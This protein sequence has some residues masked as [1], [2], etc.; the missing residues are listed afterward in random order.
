MSHACEPCR[1]ARGSVL[2]CVLTLVMTSV[3]RGGPTTYRYDGLITRADA[4]TGVDVGTKFV[5]SFLYDLGKGPT[6]VV[7]VAGGRTYEFGAITPPPVTD[8]SCGLS[9]TVGGQS[10]LERWGNV[11]L[12]VFGPGA[13]G[14]GPGSP[15]TY[16]S[17]GASGSSG[18]GAISVQL[19]FLNTERVVY[20]TFDAPGSINLDDF[21]VARFEV[22]QDLGRGRYQTLYE[23]VID[24]LAAGANPSIVP[25]PASA[26]LLGTAAGATLLLGRRRRVARAP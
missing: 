19:L 6:S 5:G 21:T 7:D 11:S 17:I 1:A 20:P 26:L 23:G 3:G 25:E 14:D 13:F 16:L 12:S 9:A 22:V 18:P 24:S 10:V 15:Q 2:A 4:S 8:S